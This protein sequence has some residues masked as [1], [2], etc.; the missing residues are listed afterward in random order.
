[1]TKF[2]KLLFTV[3]CIC[4]LCSCNKGNDFNE[5]ELGLY[6]NTDDVYE[7]NTSYIYEDNLDEKHSV[8]DFLGNPIQGIFDVYGYDYEVTTMNNHLAIYYDGSPVFYFT[9]E[10]TSAEEAL[11]DEYKANVEPEPTDIITGVFVQMHDDIEIIDGVH[12]GDTRGTIGQKIPLDN[13]S[14][15]GAESFLDKCYISWIFDNN[16]GLSPT[17]DDALIY[18]EIIYN[19]LETDTKKSNIIQTNPNYNSTE[20]LQKIQGVWI[21]YHNFQNNK[22]DGAE[23]VSFQEREYMFGLYGTDSGEFGEVLT[24][25]QRDDGKLEIEVYCPPLIYGYEEVSAEK[26]IT[27]VIGSTDNFKSVL[28]FGYKDYESNVPFVYVGNTI[29]SLNSLR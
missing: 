7:K 23:I 22:I 12:I 13:Q 21:N 25:K 29:D 6:H 4:L 5:S 16:Y 3:M 1:M 14:V 28:L 20:L 9:D 17:N 10:Y 24:V 18:A 15:L 19:K 26:Y 27:L 8:M 11:Y 2:S